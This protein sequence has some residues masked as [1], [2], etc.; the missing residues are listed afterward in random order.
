MM[1]GEYNI[2]CE[3]VRLYGRHTR[4]GYFKSERGLKLYMFND[5]L[6]KPELNRKCGWLKP[7]VNSNFFFIHCSY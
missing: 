4:M 5:K 1:E 3:V 6:C 2:D 7:N